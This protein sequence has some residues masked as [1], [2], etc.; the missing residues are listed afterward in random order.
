[1]N[2]GGGGG[3]RRGVGLQLIRKQ[4]SGDGGA[5]DYVAV[6]AR[7]NDGSEPTT[8]TDVDGIVALAAANKAAARKEKSSRRTTSL[9]NIFMSNAQGKGSLFFSFFYYFYFDPYHF[10]VYI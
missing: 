1:M 9:L 3:K 8:V 6:A 10:F 4:R 2:T 5:G 7:G